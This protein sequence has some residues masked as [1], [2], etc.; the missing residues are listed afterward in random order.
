LKFSHIIPKICTFLLTDAL[1]LNIDSVLSYVA[2]CLAA[3]ENI[4]ILNIGQI[5]GE[6][7]KMYDRY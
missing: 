3:S 1:F 7:L 5:E 4:G 2:F 6:I